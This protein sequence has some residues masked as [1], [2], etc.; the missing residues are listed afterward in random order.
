MKNDWDRAIHSLN[1][2]TV[3]S[4]PNNE[5]VNVY[6]EADDLTCVGVGT[7]AAVFRSDLAPA[8]V[9]KRYA[10]DKLFKINIEKDVYDKIGDSPYF[11][12]CFAA[13]E[14]CLVMSYEEGPTLFECLLR[15]IHVPEQAIMDVEHARADVR[16]LGLNPR[17]IHLRNILLQ[18]GRAKMLDV[19]EYVQ[20]GNDFRWEHLKRAYEEYYHL[21]DGKAVPFWLLEAI[22]KWYNHWQKQSSS[23]D[24]FMKTTYKLFHF[25][26]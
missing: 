13:T 7:D 21:F 15:G 18:N 17:D 14:K 12:T 24:E 19:S 5:P 6:G 25:K 16:Q 22:R 23:F 3:Y 10:E 4:N 26:K 9:F 8:Y 11:A 2:I 20:P 1:N